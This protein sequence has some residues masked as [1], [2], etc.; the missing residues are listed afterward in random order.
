MS[1]LDNPCRSCGLICVPCFPSMDLYKY[2]QTIN[3]HG[4]A[5]RIMTAATEKTESSRHT[6]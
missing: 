5:L 4:W 1:L 2:E 6:S 3:F